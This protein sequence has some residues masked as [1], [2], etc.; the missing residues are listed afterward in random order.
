MGT[1]KLFSIKN[2]LRE[3]LDFRLDLTEKVCNTNFSIRYISTY[4]KNFSR[5]KFVM[6][7]GLEKMAEFFYTFAEKV[8]EDL[9]S[10]FN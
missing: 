4:C 6:A 2:L 7:F 9:K 3:S 5:Q 10:D 1:R 8:F